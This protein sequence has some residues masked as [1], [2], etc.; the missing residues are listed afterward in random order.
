MIQP[1]LNDLFI[2]ALADLYGVELLGRDLFFEF[3]P[4][5]AA[6]QHLQHDPGAEPEPTDEH[7]ALV[8]IVQLRLVV[9]QFFQHLFRLLREQRRQFLFVL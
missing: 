6:V 4:L 2:F 5:V 9:P 7:L 3:S 1:L 8:E